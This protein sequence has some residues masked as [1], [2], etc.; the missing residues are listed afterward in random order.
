MYIIPCHD[1]MARSEFAGGGD[2][3]CEYKECVAD[4]RHGAVLQFRDVAEK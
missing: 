3:R 2:S 1:G 4:S